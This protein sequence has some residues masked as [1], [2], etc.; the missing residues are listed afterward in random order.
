MVLLVLSGD[1]YI[2]STFSTTELPKPPNFVLNRA[3]FHL[4]AL[5][6]F[7]SLL[8]EYK[9]SSVTTRMTDFFFPTAWNIVNSQ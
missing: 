7:I 2:L 6:H 4:F 8:L 9:I 3:H 5:A 1:L